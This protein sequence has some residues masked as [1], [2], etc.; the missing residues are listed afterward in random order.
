M[1]QIAPGVRASIQHQQAKSK[2]TAVPAAADRQERPL[3]RL[4]IQ[5]ALDD[6]SADE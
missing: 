3:D 5:V 6:G 4:A 2:A 1:I